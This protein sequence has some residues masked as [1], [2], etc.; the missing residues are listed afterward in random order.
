MCGSAFILDFAMG[1]GGRKMRRL[2]SLFIVGIVLSSTLT[3]AEEAFTVSGEVAFPGDADVI[4]KLLTKEEE[5]AGKDTP[6]E[7]LLVLKLTPQQRKHRK[8]SFN[9]IAVPKG[10]Y[11]IRC[12]Q[13]DN[14]NGLLELGFWACPLEP[15]GRYKFSWPFDWDL[16]NFLVERDI[17]GI[18]IELRRGP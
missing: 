1:R 8:A 13:D 16:S 3:F 2:L 6:Q 10:A 9:F 11:I 12:F 17:T 18:K 14:G 4:I 5:T 7:R 15:V